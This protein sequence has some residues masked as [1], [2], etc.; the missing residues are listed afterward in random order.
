MKTENILLMS[1]L[2][3]PPGE[4][5]GEVMCEQLMNQAELAQR[6]NQPVQAINEIVSGAKAI[7]PEAALQLE[8]VTGVAAHVWMG[9]EADYR[10]T[11]AKQRDSK[12]ISEQ[13][14]LVDQ[15]P[16]PELAKLGQIEKARKPE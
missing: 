14:S 8:Q 1:D 15:F 7:V 10:L 2:A 12:Q 11:L 5:L 16:Y 13:V 3:I 9:L 6:M 4:Y